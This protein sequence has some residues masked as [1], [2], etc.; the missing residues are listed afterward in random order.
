[1]LAGV[2]IVKKNNGTTWNK[3][4]REARHLSNQNFVYDN[5]GMI[6]TFF[7]VVDNFEDYYYGLVDVY[8]KAILVSCVASLE[9]SG[10][11]LMERPNDKISTH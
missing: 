7:G 10:F 5:G 11:K 6:Y 1:M 3:I 2:S 8:G 9:K 4:V